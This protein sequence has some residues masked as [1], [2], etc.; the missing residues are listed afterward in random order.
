MRVVDGAVVVGEHGG[1]EGVG[2][3]V[4]VFRKVGERHPAF[5]AMAQKLGLFMG[6]LL[7]E[8]HD[9]LE[10]VLL[11]SDFMSHSR[12]AHEK[13]VATAS[14]KKKGRARAATCAWWVRW[15]S[16]SWERDS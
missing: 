4:L 11:S 13:P 3:H 7:E 1:C 6:D 10:L 14:V 12:V 5:E 16:R 8:A 15:V 2:E 9:E